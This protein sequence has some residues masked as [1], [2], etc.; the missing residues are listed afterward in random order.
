MTRARGAYPWHTALPTRWADN[1]QYSHLNNATYFS[2][3]DTALTL[4]QIETGFLGETVD[5]PR[6]LV[7]E[8]GCRFF[9]ELRFPDLIHAGLRCGRIG[10]S[11]FTLELALFRGTSEEAAATGFFAQVQVDAQSHR[12]SPLDAPR[13]ALLEAIG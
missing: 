2:L 11:S 4:W 13:R 3:F 12:P 1:D 10:T 9:Q 5:S 8:N 6:F 7:V